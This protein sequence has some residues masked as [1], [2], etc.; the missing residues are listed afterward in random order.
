MAKLDILL[1]YGGVAAEFDVIF[2]RGER[3]KEILREKLVI[4]CY[5]DEDGYNI[6]FIAAH[7]ESRLLSAWR[8]SYKDIYVSDWNFQQA[9]VSKY[10]SV[11]FG[12]ETYVVDKVC[13][14]PHPHN[15]GGFFGHY[16]VAN[17]TNSLAI[18]TYERHSS[19]RINSPEDLK[20]T[21]TSYLELLRTVYNN[22]VLPIYDE[23]FRDEMDPLTDKLKA[24]ESK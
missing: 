5:G 4:T 23:S 9:F 11:V 10:L 13:N 20:G 8:R 21:L 1:E 3:I 17:W 14:N 16:G 22:A 2:V 19:V 18:H 12:E 6:G 24:V 15:L 7:K